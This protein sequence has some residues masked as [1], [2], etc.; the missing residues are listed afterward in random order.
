MDGNIIVVSPN[1]EPSTDPV[2]IAILNAYQQKAYEQVDAQYPRGD[3]N[4][5]QRIKFSFNH[6]SSKGT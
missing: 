4:V 3:Q 2:A 5:E 6:P 1:M